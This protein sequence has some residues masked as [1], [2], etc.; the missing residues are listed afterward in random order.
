MRTSYSTEY[1]K[2]NVEAGQ[3]TH[4]S[5]IQ[6]SFKVNFAVGDK[7]LQTD[8]TSM[9]AYHQKNCLD[10]MG[11]ENVGNQPM[12]KQ[13]GAL[14]VATGRD[15]F[16]CRTT[17]NQECYP[18]HKPPS[19]QPIIKNPTKLKVLNLFNTNPQNQ[20]VYHTQYNATHDLQTPTNQRLAD[21]Q[22]NHPQLPTYNPKDSTVS[23]ILFNGTKRV[24]TTAFKDAYSGIKAD[25]ATVS[26]PQVARNC[27]SISNNRYKDPVEHQNRYKNDYSKYEVQQLTAAEVKEKNESK[28]L[29]F[30]TYDENYMSETRKV[31]QSPGAASKFCDGSQMAVYAPIQRR[32]DSKLWPDGQLLGST[33]YQE[34]FQYKNLE[35]GNQSRN[36]RGRYENAVKIG[37]G[38]TDWSTVSR[39]TFSHQIH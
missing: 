21:A 34:T 32:A 7:D 27:F 1:Y 3:A 31:F 11:K 26:R 25:M 10:N 39:T 18:G 37:V 38:K 14:S 22:N 16:G 33:L 36:T 2:K 19:D 35:L 28:Q 29:R 12:T 5:Q 20:Q 13:R 17:T 15:Y 24:F 30:G 23:H 8:F 4:Q 9:N 6:K